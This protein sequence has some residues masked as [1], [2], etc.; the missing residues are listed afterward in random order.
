MNTK[1]NHTQFW[2]SFGSLPYRP[3]HGV[4]PR[5]VT[6]E[7]NWITLIYANEMSKRV[8]I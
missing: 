6:Y 2:S 4:K 8:L 3:N 1:I 7:N 5:K